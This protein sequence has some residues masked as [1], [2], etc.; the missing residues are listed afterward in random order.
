V[1]IITK[2]EAKVKGST[3]FFTGQPCLK[4]HVVERMVSDG[5]CI[6]CKRIR[7]KKSYDSGTRKEYVKKMYTKKREVIL[8]DLKEHYVYSNER[9]EYLE[10]WRNANVDNI[11]LYRKEHAGLFAY[12]AAC[13]RKKVKQATPLWFD[14]EKDKIK[15]LYLEASRLKQETGIEHHVDHIIPISGDN[16]CGLH[17]LSNLQVITRTENL[18]KKNNF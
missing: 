7:E 18:E 1:D 4:G 8:A 14:E 11:A 9:K 3:R 6:Q 12:H 16:V 15:Q 2:L 5:Y 17:T 13:R 10:K